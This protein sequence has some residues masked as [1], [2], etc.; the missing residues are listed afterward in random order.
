MPKSKKY[1]KKPRGY[2]RKLAN[3]PHLYNRNE[4]AHFGYAYNRTNPTYESSVFH[5]GNERFHELEQL[6]SLKRLKDRNGMQS[7]LMAENFKAIESAYYTGDRWKIGAELRGIKERMAPLTKSAP[8]LKSV[9]TDDG[10][11][12]VHP[13]P[14]QPRTPAR[15]RT[16][17]P[18]L[19]RTPAPR[20]EEGAPPPPPPPPPPGGAPAAGGRRTQTPPRTPQPTD[21]SVITD[22]SGNTNTSANPD[23]HYNRAGLDLNS[24]SEMGA[25]DDDS[26]FIP[27]QSA[28]EG[29]ERQQSNVRRKAAARNRS[30][31]LTATDSIRSIQGSPTQVSSRLDE[32]AVARQ[33]S[34]PRKTGDQVQRAAGQ[35]SSRTLSR[36]P[37]R[38]SS[39]PSRPSRSS[40]TPSRTR[41]PP[42]SPPQQTLA[43]ALADVEED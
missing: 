20:A 40:S 7:S 24:P 10:V 26:F 28:V 41:T 9:L 19:S 32:L 27:T 36:N 4:P 8:R 25:Q 3:A 5:R 39:T 33:P 22:A 34:R 23:G 16:P 29:D 2:K 38:T 15:P 11:N 42:R 13:P 6:E 18:I 17:H 14:L 12:L 30:L 43:E 37:S 21:S 1:R 35:P 31:S